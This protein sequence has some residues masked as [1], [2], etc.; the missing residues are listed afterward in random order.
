MGDATGAGGRRP[1]AAGRA[2]PGWQPT[3]GAASRSPGDQFLVKLIPEA[4]VVVVIEADA[5]VG[6][7]VAPLND[8]VM[9]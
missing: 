3:P 6:V 4:P 5:D 9:V 7:N 1:P 2:G 8:G